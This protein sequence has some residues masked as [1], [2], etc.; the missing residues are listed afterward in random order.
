M[1]AA[2][3]G[4]PKKK[5]KNYPCT[6]RVDGAEDCDDGNDAETDAGWRSKTLQTLSR[7]DDIAFA[8]TVHETW[9]MFGDPV[10]AVAVLA[11]ANA[12]KQSTTRVRQ[13]SLRTL[14]RLLSEDISL[15]R[16]NTRPPKMA[17]AWGRYL[18]ILE[19]HDIAHREHYELV[20]HTNK[21]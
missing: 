7:L 11:R 5:R 20:R 9:L 2:S 16:S 6:I 1:H 21:R 10:A 15:A 3:I 17:A 4:E 14:R 12:N 18:S 8:E 13:C 19:E